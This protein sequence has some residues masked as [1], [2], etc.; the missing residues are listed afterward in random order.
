MSCSHEWA[1]GSRQH[2]A[3]QALQARSHLYW[4]RLSYWFV[5]GSKIVIRLSTTFCQ[6]QRIVATWETRGRQS[7]MPRRLVSIALR[8]RRKLT[9]PGSKPKLWR[10][11]ARL[12]Q[13]IIRQPSDNYQTTIRQ[14]SDKY[15]KPMN[16]YSGQ[17]KKI[18]IKFFFNTWI[19][20]HRIF[21]FV[22]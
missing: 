15:Q 7:Q 5:H 1:S 22:W 4:A 16:P 10:E 13:T 6:D 11:A 8:M 20:K 3:V 14:L 2:L 9:S 21:I 17:K 18:L 12:C 19:Q